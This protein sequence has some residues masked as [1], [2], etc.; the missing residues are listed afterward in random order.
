MEPTSASDYLQPGQGWRPVVE[1]AGDFHHGAT[2][3]VSPR[4]R[5]AKEGD[6]ARAEEA[7]GSV[8]AL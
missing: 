2:H 7:S 6:V 1:G 4:L 8:A 5:E 3:A